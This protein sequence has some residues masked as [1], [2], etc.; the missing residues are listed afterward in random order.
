[1]YPMNHKP[2]LWVGIDPRPPHAR[3]L[4]RSP[5]GETLLKA[6][7]QRHPRHPRA[8]IA[9]LEAL[10]LWQGL[11]ARGALAVGEEEPWCDMGRFGV[12]SIDLDSTPLCRIDLVDSLRRKRPR[13]RI[14]GMGNFRDLMQMDFF[15]EEEAAHD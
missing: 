11:P 10:A 5:S 2:T 12:G 7:L 3:I 15:A 14:G 13:D 9:L 1:M 6:R 8:L 4:V